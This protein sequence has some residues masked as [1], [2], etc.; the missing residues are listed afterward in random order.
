[1]PRQ[2]LEQILAA[3]GRPGE[4]DFV[5]FVGADPVFPLALRVGEAGAAAIAA[6]GVGASDLWQ[7][8]TGRRQSV[9]VEVEAAAAQMKSNHYLKLEPAPGQAPPTPRAIRNWDIFRTRDERW[10]YLHREFAHHRARIAELLK[11]TDEP[12]SLT[13]AVKTWD[14]VELEDAVHACGACAG[15]VRTYDEW[16]ATEQGRILQDLPL[17]QITRIGDSPVEPLPAGDRPLSRIRALDLTRV[18]AG[19]TCARTLAEHGA[20]VLRIGT[21]LLPNNPRHLIDT[22]HGKRS[23]V[24]D[25]TSEEGVEQLRTLVRGADVFSQSYR[26]G[27]LSARGFSLEAV[28]ALRPGIVYVSL[29]AFGPNGPWSARRGFD[30]L[31]QSVSGISDEYSLEGKPRLLPVSAL[32][33]IAGYLAAYGVMVALQ[34]RAQEGGSYHVQVSLAQTGLWL[35]RQGRCEADLVVAA[36][37]DL[38]PERVA[39]LSVTTD[40]PFGRLSHL[41]PAVRM[42]ETDAHW[43]RPT[44]PLDHDPPSWD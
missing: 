8:R 19:P 11:C 33:Y 31:V 4:V 42:S 23:T 41:R 29:S 43:E 20:D 14:A 24:L 38:P 44:V 10:L 18:L 6:T 34:R 15:V 13:A 3:A 2:M 39:A 9:S 40:T 21:D 26:P 32:D 37:V 30:T 17:L 16:Q 35:T 28:A 25:L 36:P 12:E 5:Q 7:L 27:A 1:M 22:G